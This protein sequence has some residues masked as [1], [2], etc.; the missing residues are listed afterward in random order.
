LLGDKKKFGKIW[1]VFVKVVNS[2]NFAK[3]MKV[4]GQTFKMTQN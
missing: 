3:K 4:F 1:E 2:T